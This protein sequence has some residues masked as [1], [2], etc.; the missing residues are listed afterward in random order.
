VGNTRSSLVYGPGKILDRTE[1]QSGQ[2]EKENP[3]GGLPPG[4]VNVASAV[5]LLRARKKS[6][7]LATATVP[8][9]TSFPAVLREPSDLVMPVVRQPPSLT[10]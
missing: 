1:I 3:L 2:V 9:G 4:W 7:D 6:D 10:R 5:S 8:A